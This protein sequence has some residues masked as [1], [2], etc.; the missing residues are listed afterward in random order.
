MTK[1]EL[2]N[3]MAAKAGITKTEAANAINAITDGVV[4]SLKPKNGKITLTGLGTFSKSRRKAR[5]G[6]NPRTG[7]PLKIKATNVVR[8]KPSQKLKGAI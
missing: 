6:R 4:K 2:I 3:H 5:T 1:A 8:F 7:E